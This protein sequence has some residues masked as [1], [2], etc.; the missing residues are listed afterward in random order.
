MTNG[1]QNILTSYERNRAPVS[2]R[3]STMPKLIVKTREGT[4]HSVN[5]PAGASAMEAMRDGGIDEVLALCGGM[6]ACATCH[7]HV[8]REFAALLPPMGE[9]ENAL[10]DG[11]SHRNQYSRLS[12]QIRMSDELSGLRVTVANE[13]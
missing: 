11:S 10:L 13:D 2:E 12:C 3:V 7:V 6:C 4:E 8:D 9:D 5:A 1:K